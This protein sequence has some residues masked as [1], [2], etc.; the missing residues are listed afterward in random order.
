MSYFV[1]C[2]SPR[3]ETER[4]ILQLETEVNNS[5]T[6]FFKTL[7]ATQHLDLVLA[8]VCE[9]L[10]ARIEDEYSRNSHLQYVNAVRVFA[11]LHVGVTTLSSHC[12]RGQPSRK[13]RHSSL[14]C[15][16]GKHLPE[17]CTQSL[18]RLLRWLFHC[19]SHSKPVDPDHF[20]CCHIGS[21]PMFRHGTSN[22]MRVF[23]SQ[24]RR[25]V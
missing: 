23:L 21:N 3:T 16:S 18:W 17:L 8:T 1:L 2:M 19:A 6:K 25:R 4:P 13:R 22:D 12:L 11:Y 9:R 7:A 20:P 14:H 24:N 5:L 15:N 10:W